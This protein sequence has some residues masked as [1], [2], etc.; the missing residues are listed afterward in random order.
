MCNF[1]RGHYGEHS[2]D[3]ILKDQEISFKEIIYGL[4]D[5]WMPNDGGKP[6]TI[7]YPEHSAKYKSVLSSINIFLSNNN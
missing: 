7:A 4:T 2:F 3:I 1:G 5:A 6:I